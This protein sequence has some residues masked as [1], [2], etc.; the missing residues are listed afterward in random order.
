MANV[1][2]KFGLKPV[3]SLDGSD[4]INAQNRYR[5]A[6]SY[7][8]AIFQGDLVTPVTGGGI[9]RH[10]AGSGTPVV[11]VFN[12]CF[13]TDPTTS[14]PT[15]KNYYPGSIAA[16]DIVANVIDSPDQVYK[17]DSD[18]AFAVADIFK[19]FHVTNVSGN[20]ATGTSEVQLDYSNSGIQITLALQAIDISQDVDNN[21]AGAVNVDV[22]VRINN[23]FYKTGTA[24]LA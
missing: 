22:L 10:T 17:I 7:A 11:G 4:F 6:S 20:T 5:I 19:N 15:W 13:Y 24:G 14:K 1:A 16:S 23:H 9:E 2:E 12:G 8:T 21:E 18:G 3:R